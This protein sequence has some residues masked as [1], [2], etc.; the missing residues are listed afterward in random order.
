M[1]MV[2]N[3]KGIQISAG[4]FKARC[5]SLLDLV[6]SSHQVVTITKRGKPVARL[7]PL[8]SEKPRRSFGWLSGLVIAESDIVEPTGAQWEAESDG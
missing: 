4:E 8:A 6:G 7:V 2:T 3:D 1:S 5:L